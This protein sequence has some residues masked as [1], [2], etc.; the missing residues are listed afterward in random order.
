MILDKINTKK[1]IHNLFLA[2]FSGILIGTSYI[3][4]PPWAIF[5]GYVP[6]WYSL[7]HESSLK[8]VFFKSLACQ[9]VL[10]FIGFYWI[11][12]D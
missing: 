4:F 7:L 2:L 10:S 1:N 6:L 3:P 8:Q 9:F 12:L 5:F 11:L